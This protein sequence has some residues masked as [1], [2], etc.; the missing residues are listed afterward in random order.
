MSKTRTYKKAENNF[1][2]A[3]AGFFK[4]VFRSIADGVMKFING[5]RKKLTVMI[6]PHSQK[7]VVNFQTSIFS[8]VF[9]SVLFF[10]VLISFFWFTTKSLSAA[11]E[12]ASLKEETRKAQASLSVLKHETNDLLKVANNFKGTL[13]STLTSLGLQSIMENDSEIDD[14]S[15]LTTLF[16]VKESARG[17]AKEIHE[18]RK[19]AS[20]LKDSTQPVKEMGE[21]LDTQTALF[22]DIP[23]LWPIKG[24]LGQITF[25]F[26]QN[27]HPFTGHWY[28]HTG[29]DLATGRRGDPVMATADGQ[30]IFADKDGGWGNYVMI[31]HKHG[32]YTR[33]AHLQSFRVT[34]GEQVQKGQIIGYIG[35]TGNSTGPHLHYEVHIG[36][37]VVDPMKYLNI[38]QKIRKK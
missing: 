30:V 28:I 36:S 7:K 22:S 19:F 26:G 14:S 38:K 12:L 37:D 21:L 34:K 10:G 29:I 9:I 25:P 31:K 3:V 17:S 24:G 5:G 16:S 11:K 2:K 32:F 4:S 18:M 8:I 13:S 33:Y 15:D 27:R 23:S 1:V 6:V 35:N 20:Y